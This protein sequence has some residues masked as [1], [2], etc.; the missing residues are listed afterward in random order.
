MHVPIRPLRGVDV[1]RHLVHDRGARA[2]AP[3]RVHGNVRNAENS[4]QFGAENRF[5]FT[6]LFREFREVLTFSF[7]PQPVECLWLTTAISAEDSPLTKQ[8]CADGWRIVCGTAVGAVCG[9]NAGR[10]S[11]GECGAHH[12]Q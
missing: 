11:G 1:Q 9:G 6:I 7:V 2:V 5:I 3:V 12:A 8:L 4:F 10:L